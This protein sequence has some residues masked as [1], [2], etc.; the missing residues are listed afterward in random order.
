MTQ[1]RYIFSISV[2][3]FLLVE[4]NVR[5]RGPPNLLAVAHGPPV[6]N[7]WFKALLFVTN[8]N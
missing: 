4:I 8:V 2:M 3:F 6:E 1:L 7:D 5:R